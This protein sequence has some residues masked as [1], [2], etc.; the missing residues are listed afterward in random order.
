LNE[1]LKEKINESLSGVLPIT[2]IVLI[3]S[4]TLVPMEIGTVALFLVEH[5]Y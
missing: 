5:C 4:I 1:R 3:L 2:V